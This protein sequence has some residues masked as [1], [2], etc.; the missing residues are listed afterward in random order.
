MNRRWTIAMLLA[1]GTVVG[2]GVPL[3][4]AQEFPALPVG[5]QAPTFER[6]PPRLGYISGE[7]SFR[8]PGAS[9]WA[10]AQVNTPLAP[11]DALYAGPNGNF[12]IQIG[13]RAFVRATGG[14]Q[15]GLDNYEPDFLQFRVTA[16]HVSLDLRELP[17]GQTVEVD[18]PN[19]AFTIDRTG[20]YRVDVAQDTTIFITRRGGRAMITPAAGPAAAITPSEQVVITGTDFPRVE[21]YVAPQLTE[22]DRWNYARTDQLIENLSARYVSPMVYGVDDLDHYGTWRVVPNYGAVWVP[23][24]PPAGWAPYSTGRWIWDPY[25]EWTWVDDAPWGWAPYHYGRWVFVDGFWTWA[26]GPVVARPY[27][28]PALVAFFGGGSGVGRPVGWVAL[29][30]GEPVIPWWGPAGFVGAPWWAGWG[31]PRTTTVV[32][33]TNITVYRN[34]IVNRA[35]VVVPP[36]R[37]GHG[38]PVASA[39]LGQVDVR[40]L[41]PI[42]GPLEIKPAPA[43][44]V[45]GIGRAVRPPEGVQRRPVVVTRP[46]HDVSPVLRAQGLGTPGAVAPPPPSRVV[47]TPPGDVTAPARPPC[48]PQNGPVRPRPPQPPRFEGPARPESPPSAVRRPPGEATPSARLEGPPR[49]ETPRGQS[50]PTPAEV[51]RPPRP[52]P[53]GGAPGQGDRGRP[54]AVATP[55]PRGARPGPPPSAQAP[56]LHEEKGNHS[57]NLPGEPANRLFPGPNTKQQMEPRKSGGGD[58]APDSGPARPGARR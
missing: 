31:G 41:T 51:A 8:R 26:P 34:V 40:S 25:Y 6:T 56:A 3:T 12:E 46:P 57:R 14:A 20:Y 43:S 54:P 55:E 48:G 10:P 32:N 33:V 27:Y 15:L 37:F 52:V 42:R 24:A 35:V 49:P 29:G 39:R 22:W 50:R 17:V 9:D 18:T 1:M 5:T 7:V 23:D 47:S 16:G 36:D 45:P 2:G 11:G 21:A 44:L 19:A 53:P 38:H 58:V 30:W 28:C 13:A 4:R